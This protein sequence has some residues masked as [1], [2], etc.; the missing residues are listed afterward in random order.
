M[1][2]GSLA[3][4]AIDRLDDRWQLWGRAVPMLAITAGGEN[5]QGLEKKVRQLLA[6]PEIQGE[7]RE[8]LEEGLRAIHR[9]ESLKRERER[10]RQRRQPKRKPRSRRGGVPKLRLDV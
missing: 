4:A 5:L 8:I 3:Q 9:V 1:A 7:G 10:P 2:L 6:S